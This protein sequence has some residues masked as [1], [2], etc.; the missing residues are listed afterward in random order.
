MF[1]TRCTI[2]LAAE[3]IRISTRCRARNLED[4]LGGF[5]R[6]FQTLMMRDV[7]DALAPDNPLIINTGLL[8]GTNIMTGLRTYFLRLSVR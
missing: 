1:Y 5:G 8:T 4:V 3:T 2:D 6:S 7:T